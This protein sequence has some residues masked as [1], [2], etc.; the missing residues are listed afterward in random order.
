M[1]LVMCGLLAVGLLGGTAA[2]GQPSAVDVPPALEAWRGWALHGKG[3]LGCPFVYNA[4]AVEPAAFMC[5]WPGRL[6]LVLDAD[7]GTF[8]QPWTV[9]ENVPVPLPGDAE[10]WPREVAVDGR[11]ATVVLRAGMPT[12]WLAP[13]SYRLSGQFTWRER[14]ASLPLPASVGL[15]ALTLDG[16]PVPLPRRGVGL[17]LGATAGEEAEADALAVEVYRRFDDD[18]PTRLRTRLDLAVAGGVREERLPGVVPAGFLPLRMGSNLPVR[19]DEDG[20]LRVQVRPGNWYVD[21]D[22]RAEAVLDRMAMATPGGAMPSVEFWSFAAKPAL[23]SV[24][25]EGARP[26]DPIRAGSI[27]HRLPTF[28]LA[29]GDALTVV[30]R[31]RG[32]LVAANS[33]AATRHLWLD[34]NRERFTF[35]DAIS[36]EMRVGWRLDVQPPYQLLAATED[37]SDLLVTRGGAGDATGIE[38][39]TA[40]VDVQALGRIERGGAMPVAGWQSNMELAATLHLPPGNKLLAALGVENAPTS[41]IGQWRLLDFFVLLVVTIA[42]VRLFGRVAGL[43]ALVALTLSFHEPG[44]PVWTWLNLLA[45]VALTRVAPPGR[46]LR[47]ARSYRLASFA[48]L[49]LLLIPFGIAQVRLAVYPQLEPERHRQGQT[50]GLFEMLAGEMQTPVA[51]ED[52]RA[53]PPRPDTA[54]SVSSDATQPEEVYEMVVT[55]SYIRRGNFDLPGSDALGEDNTPTQAGAGKPSWRWASHPLGW[56]GA[57]SPESTMRL[58]IVPPWLTGILRLVA[59]AALGLFAA[60]FA[61]DLLGRTW[62][63]PRWPA[64]G[65]A[66]AASAA[67]IVVAAIVSAQSAAAQTPAPALLEALEERL[68]EPPPCTPACAEIVHA[69][70]SA[71]ASELAITLQVHALAAVAVPLPGEVGGWLPATVTAGDA[72]VPVQDRDGALWAPVT[73]GRHTLALRGPLPPGAA[74][75]IHFPAPPRAIAAASEHW[76]V[77]GIEDGTLPGS[78][79]SLTRLRPDREQDRAAPA[80]AQWEASHMPAFVEIERTL[81]FG[82]RQW[83]VATIVRRV[84]PDGLAPEGGVVNLAVPLLAGE[85]IVSAEHTVAEGTV[86]VAMDPSVA[87][88]RWRSTLPRVAAMSLLATADQPWREIW[89]FEI[90]PAWRVEFSGLPPSH[91]EGENA[92]LMTFHPRPGET[93]TLAI[94]RPETVPG[95]TLAFDRVALETTAS[96]S[97]RQAALVLDYRSTRGG[98]QTIRLPAVAELD[99]VAIDGTSES[100]PLLDGELNLPILPGTHEVRIGWRENVAVAPRVATPVVDLGAPAANVTTALTLPKRWLLFATGPSLGPAVLYWSELLA[101]IV[102]ALV[103]GRIQTTPLRTWHWLLLGLGFSTFSWLAF[104]V[105][106]GWLLAYGAREQLTQGLSRLW[107]NTAQIAFGLLALLAFAAILNS[108]PNGLLGEPDMSVAGFGSSGDNLRWFA[109]QTESVT[110]EAAVWSLPLWVYKGLILAWAL[111]LTLALLRWLPWAWRRFSVGGLWQPKAAAPAPAA[112]EPVAAEPT[113]EAGTPPPTKDVW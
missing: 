71:G 113:P 68:L 81:L 8:S 39:R 112:S 50:I 54:A 11:P 52:V 27:W 61:F 43:T 63:L 42:T 85:S 62:Q 86:K 78:T 13:G 5:A 18:V 49:L 74:V 23:R 38:L 37:G 29:A 47:L 60:R 7:G 65:G 28:Q 15:V 64:R 92:A 82:P 108:I 107:Y 93:L 41:W 80:M 94:T 88:F 1:R 4:S 105:V 56:T 110:P 3:Y 57:V 100:L 59:I 35:A 95:G 21:I 99:A 36:G 83:R 14:P 103:L 76:F 20:Q 89:R 84:T 12:V 58:I 70:V 22:A 17:W 101:L 45:A 102:A 9:Y 31:S 98:S 44:A 97:W 66:T 10:H 90:S 87:N 67:A 53:G 40:Q 109:D 96:D 24:L 111:W 75:E 16:E 73:S 34:F 91:P 26:V 72:P 48:V 77:A 32:Q 19:L 79:L 51:L 104:G 6:D 46:L 33:L 106:A 2:W 30:E 55:G 25:V 69:D